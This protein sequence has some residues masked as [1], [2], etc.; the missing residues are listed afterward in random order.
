VILSY[1]NIAPKSV[2]RVVLPL[3][4]I[5]QAVHQRHV[6]AILADGRMGPGE[7]VDVEAAVGKAAKA[8]PGLLAIDEA[9]AINSRFPAFESIDVPQGA[10][11]GKPPTP[12]DTVTTLAVTYRLVAPITTL[13]FTAGAIGQS[14]FATKAKLIAETPTAKE[15]EAPDPDDKNPALP[16]HPGERHI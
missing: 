7:V 3:A 11:R 6:A 8:A 2:K 13:N 16:V 5:G 15:I 1:Y 12:D 14:I 10:F 9:D 4:E